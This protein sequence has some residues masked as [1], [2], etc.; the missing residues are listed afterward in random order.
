MFVSFRC[1]VWYGLGWRG[2][3]KWDSRG[4]EGRLD[5]WHDIKNWKIGDLKSGVW[6]FFFLLFPT[7]FVVVV[8]G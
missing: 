1:V 3:G 5:E 4:M 6:F 7:G 2:G 8:V